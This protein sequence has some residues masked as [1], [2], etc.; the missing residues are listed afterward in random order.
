MAESE[1]GGPREEAGA[2]AAS[3]RSAKGK[4]PPP[5]P[6][7]RAAMAQNISSSIAPPPRAEGAIT[8]V[9]KSADKSEAPKTT[10]IVQADAKKVASI[11]QTEMKKTA[12]SC[13]ANTPQQEQEPSI[14]IDMGGGQL[15]SR[16]NPINESGKRVAD[17]YVSKS[18]P[19][20]E[21]DQKKEPV[22]FKPQARALS[23]NAARI[24]AK[25]RAMMEGQDQAGTFRLPGAGPDTTD[26]GV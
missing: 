18:L 15:A 14:E 10:S 20:Q 3:I 5:S 6:A 25:R 21:P 13:A 11:G 23:A 26:Q 12:Q 7:H 16:R 4:L 8:S 2:A 1:K 19:H 17:L 24:I 22:A 9:K